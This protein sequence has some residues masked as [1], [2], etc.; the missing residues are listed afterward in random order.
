[1]RNH[2]KKRIISIGIIVFFLFTSATTILANEVKMTQNN[3]L[4]KGDVIYKEGCCEGYTLCGIVPFMLL[5]E[6]HHALLIDMNGT[7]I[8]RWDTIPDPAKMLPGGS[9]ISATGEYI[10]EWDSTNLTQLSWDGEVEWDFSNWVQDDTGRFMA[11][12]HH[13]FQ[14]EGNPVGYYVPGQDFITCGKTL[15]LAHNTINNQNVS[16]KTVTD[17]VIYEVYWNGTLTGFEWHASDHIDE[18]GFNPISRQGIWFNPG[19]PGL[20]LGCLPGD[21]IHINSMSLLG[22]NKWYDE[23]DERFNPENIML[24]SRHGSFIAIISRETGEIIWRIGPDYSRNTEEG[25]KLG[26]LIGLHNAHIIP[27]GLPG[28]GN[29]LL[30]DNGGLAGYGIFGIPNQIR[31][32]SRVIEFN[33]MTFEIVQEYTDRWGLYPYPRNGESHKLFSATMCSVQRLPNGNTLITESLSGR[34]FEITLENEVVWD[35]VTLDKKNVIYR[36]YRIPPEWI[37]GN[38]SNYSF[39]EDES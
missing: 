37:P 35:Y 27:K 23:G 17:D 38:P 4:I 34:I 33:P 30:F 13:D 10:D 31:F 36:A 39:W 20:L 6:G 26:A 24:S 3:A 9:V 29:I 15:I 5:G 21:W 32:Y 1:M 14:R 22:E 16:R 25:R 28:E 19:G 18:M 2:L 11:R 12:E 8:N 7:E